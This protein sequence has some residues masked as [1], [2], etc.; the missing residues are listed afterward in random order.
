MGRVS[1]GRELLIIRKFFILIPSS[2]WIE[3]ESGYGRVDGWIS[4]WEK[5]G[6]NESGID[7]VV[8]DGRFDGERGAENDSADTVVERDV[9]RC[10]S[11]E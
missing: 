2:G 9:G 11:G 10:N 8:D 5:F 3:L 7:S 4:V 6:D 1:G